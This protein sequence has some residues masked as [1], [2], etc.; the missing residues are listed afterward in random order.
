VN[1]VGA[2]IEKRKFAV[3]LL[4]GVTGS[5]KTEVYLRAVE[6]VLAAGGS[7]IYLVPEVALTP[8]T[9][10]RLRESQRG[11]VGHSASGLSQTKLLFDS[12]FFASCD[13]ATCRIRIVP[14]GC[15]SR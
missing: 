12:V 1:S 11:Q 10:A 4:N 8:Q 3:H 13:G 6:Q 5:G 2:S 7:A 15:S 14:S 9:V